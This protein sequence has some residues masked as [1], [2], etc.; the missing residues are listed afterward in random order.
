MN[1]LW[2]LFTLLT[3]FAWGAGEFFYKAGNEYEDSY[4]AQR[5]VV[6]VGFFFGLYVL[7]YYG[8]IRQ[9]EFDWMS[10]LIYLPVSASYII[11]MWLG[12][13]GL[14]YLEVSI[15]G[16]VSNASGAVSA[17]FLVIFSH[18]VISGWA[19]VAIALVTLGIIMISKSEDSDMKELEKTAE[20]PEEAKRYRIGSVAILF[21]IGYMIFDS[22]GTFF[23]GIVLDTHQLDIFGRNFHWELAEDQ[24]QMSYMLTFF[25]LGLIMF[26]WL[27]FVKKQ[28]WSIRDE[29]Y[30]G[31]AAILETVGQVFYVFAMSGRSVLAA[32]LIASYAVFSVILGH[33]FL[34]ERLKPFAYIAVI[35]VVIGTIIIGVYDY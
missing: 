30:R 10:L 5:T 19:W 15:V 18:E 7:V 3:I 22:L 27:T 14:R 32:P 17:I 20:T 4:S 25:F 12:Y 13:I 33:I 8:G 24:A 1:N 21:P 9:Y 28:R 11:S 35:L 34:K 2:F 23:D 6:M 16:P 29:K 26:C 31:V